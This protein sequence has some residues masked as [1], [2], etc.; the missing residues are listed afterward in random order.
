MSRENLF[1]PWHS[2]KK[3]QSQESLDNLRKDIS[4]KLMDVPC[5]FLP[6]IRMINDTVW[7]IST[8][9]KKPVTYNTGMQFCWEE[10]DQDWPTFEVKFNQDCQFRFI[11][12]Q[13]WKSRKEVSF[14][15]K[16][17]KCLASLAFLMNFEKCELWQCVIRD[18]LKDAGG[19]YNKVHL[20]LKMMVL[21]ERSRE[22][23][24]CS[25]DPS[26]SSSQCKF[27]QLQQ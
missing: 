19:Y 18:F 25:F 21:R 14:N 10:E 1:L 7:S 9:A 12:S 23:H 20:G 13:C 17:L 16:L 11:H 22:M 24:F 4:R 6:G 5:T 3:T 27:H 26:S 15:D 8:M 2:S